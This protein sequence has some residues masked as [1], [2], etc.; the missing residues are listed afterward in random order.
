[1]PVII[2][3]K[4]GVNFVGDTQNL[5]C[6]ECK[7]SD[8]ELDVPG[9][10]KTAQCFCRDCQCQFLYNAEN[11]PPVSI[12]VEHGAYWVVGENKK[13]LSE[14]PEC[15]GIPVINVVRDD[16]KHVMKVVGGCPVCNC[17]FSISRSLMPI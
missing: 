8:C 17:E 7:S 9:R 13:I 1:M 3:E 6:P 15:T 16:S 12:V 4:R 10:E 14:C 2:I 11:D 5:R